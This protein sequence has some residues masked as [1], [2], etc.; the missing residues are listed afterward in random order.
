MP[1]KKKHQSELTTVTKIGNDYPE[2]FKKVAS[3]ADKKIIYS[4]VIDEENWFVKPNNVQ[5]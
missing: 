2:Y 3:Y 4:K 1:P 5:K